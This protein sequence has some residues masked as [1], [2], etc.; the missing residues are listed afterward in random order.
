LD[1][2]CRGDEEMRDEIRQLLASFDQDEE[3]MESP[4]VAEV[5]ETIVG[6]REVLTAGQRVQRYE[7]IRKIGAG[8]MGEVFLATDTEL[9]RPVALKL[10][11]EIYAGDQTRVSRFIRE[12]KAASALNHPNIITIYEIMSVEGSYL[13]ATEFIEGETLRSRQRHR[14][15]LL[16]EV[17]EVASQIS[18]AL[19]A[20]HNAGIVHRDIKPENIMLRN[21]GLVKVLD[22]GLAKLAEKQEPGFAS[23]SPG[24][25][26]A[27]D[28]GMVMGTLSYMSPEQLRSTSDV[29]SR[30]DIWSLGVVMYEAITG[31]LPFKGGSTSDVIASILKSEPSHLSYEYPPE[32][33]RIVAKTLRKERPER[34]QTVSDLTYDLKT[35]GRELESSWPDMA[36]SERAPVRMADTPS[37]L[38]QNLQVQRFSYIH[39]FSILLI[40]AGLFGGAW[41]YFGVGGKSGTAAT[42]S[43]KNVEVANWS[44]APGE[45][46]TTG[47]FSPDGKMIAFT[48]SKSGTRDIWIKQVASGEA[49][50][51]T[52]DG[53][54]NQNPVWSPDGSELAYF[55]N[56]G[57]RYGIWRI[58]A[59]GGSPSLMASVEDGGTSLQ[60]WS[61]RNLIY[62][63]SP[64]NPNISAL[65]V[66]SGQIAPVTGIESATEMSIS[67]NEELV[68]YIVTEGEEKNLW[69]ASVKDGGPRQITKGGAEVRQVVWHPDNRRILYDANVNGLF[70]IFIT[71][72]DGAP[73]QQ[74]TSFDKDSVVTDVSADGTRILYGW[75]REESD[76]WGVDL[77]DAR[78]FTVAADIDAELWAS[79]AGNSIAYQS[80]KSLGQG[81]Q[82]YSGA[83][84]VKDIRSDKPASQLMQN[85]FLPVWSP[86]GQQLAFMQLE[87]EDYQIKA[88]GADGGIPRQLTTGGALPAA[89]TK[90]PYNRTQKN[91]YSWSPD[92]RGIA[93]SS[94]RGGFSNIWLAAGDGAGEKQ[95]TDNTDKTLSLVCPIWS[96]DGTRM[97]YAT[98]SRQRGANNNFTYT[99]LVTPTDKAEPKTVFQTN[100]FVRL[101][102]W[103]QNENSLIIASGSG[104]ERLTVPPEVTLFQ[105]SVD[106]GVRTPIATIKNAY[107]FNI[108]L[109]VDRK[110]IAF[111]THEDG[112]DNLSV[113]PSAGGAIKRI[114]GNNDPRLYFSKLSWASDGSR[115]YFGK[116]MRYSLLSML[117]DFK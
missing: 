8:G 67:P 87:G 77:A 31:D 39:I 117:N 75:A 9:E 92:S 66:G 50:Q 86:D 71:D 24:L 56:R 57:D 51:I 99:F 3:F 42:A 103:S 97:A 116:Q 106:T 43:L 61:S 73:P 74:I 82:I 14:P 7:V 94:T 27:T 32:L 35:F 95:F 60:S 76:I 81:D 113:M 54:N 49:I 100:Y 1:E 79:S 69:V 107:I 96:A 41:W 26:I 105:I 38:T 115:I 21:D 34:Y 19:S 40:A 45:Q 114:T 25:T 48:S 108:D 93:F 52:K 59:F 78:E 102:G 55:S 64:L 68:A 10:L 98:R 12:A 5:A 62:F 20:A 36:I 4:A 58:P 89:F 83:I 46:I 37:S 110:Q 16:P 23:T 84:F 44:S 91:D 85:A 29:D 109:S 88:I 70:Q 90:L 72:I 104:D 6:K 112:K 53:Y 63:S 18:A 28:P 15:L 22:F 30:A 2:A 11:P 33:G 47:M 111:V 13:I 80:V 17:I 65:D 101:L